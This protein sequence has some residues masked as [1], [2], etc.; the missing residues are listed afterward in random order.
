MAGIF[1]E[2]SQNPS[3]QALIE[4]RKARHC[5][6]RFWL[7]APVD[8]LEILYQSQIGQA[9]R[10]MLQ[11]LLPSQSL[12]PGE[13]AWRQAL[14]RRLMENFD[15]PETTNLLLAT[16]PY[17]DRGKMR[18]ANPMQQVPQW[19]LADYAALCD[20]QLE[21]QLRRPV[22]LLGP[23]GSTGLGMAYPL[24][25]LGV[26]QP[27]PMPV[28]PPLAA[29]LP[30]MA[31]RRGNEALALIQNQ[32][33]IGRMSGLINLYSI[34]PRDAEV[35]RELI[36]L[37]RQMGQIWLDVNPAQLQALYQSSFGQLYRNFLSCGFAREALLPDDQ[38]LRAQLA[39]VVGNMAQP[40]ALNALLA[41]LPF[42]QPGRIQFG[43][44][45]QFIPAWL[46]QD[47]QALN[48]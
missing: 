28:Q 37:R 45:Q 44:G 46:L 6:S 19:L 4:A 48:N 30:V 17:F 23:A 32:E 47:I 10:L 8:Q 22:G 7:A 33:F 31:A 13:Q 15:R 36:G 3:A 20:P 43:G 18:V 25:Q 16:M 26:P 1:H 35:K 24:Q 2:L 34:D 9:Y 11:G 27:V 38:Q 14:S 5:L 42:F 12:E 41:A 21:Q 40:R 29:A 39:Q